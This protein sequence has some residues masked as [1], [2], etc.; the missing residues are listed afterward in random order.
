MCDNLSTWIADSLLLRTWLTCVVTRFL[1]APDTADQAPP[2]LP[3]EHDQDP[4]CAGRV[5]LRSLQLSDQRTLTI[6]VSRLD[7]ARCMVISERYRRPSSS[8]SLRRP[9]AP[10]T[11]S[12]RQYEL[13]RNI[14][15]IEPH[16][17]AAPPSTSN[18]H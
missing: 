17:T 6:D 5:A 14:D 16:Y 4:P 3:Q 1:A 2:S 12:I 7:Y 11:V 15:K 8:M 13:C 9:I 10:N 18:A